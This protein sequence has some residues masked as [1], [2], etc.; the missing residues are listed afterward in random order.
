M[1]KHGSTEAGVSNG[2]LGVVAGAAASTSGVG[3]TGTGRRKT[4]FAR[5]ART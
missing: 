2:H 5:T 4:G 1:A 3:M